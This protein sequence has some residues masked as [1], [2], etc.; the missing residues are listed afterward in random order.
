MLKFPKTYGPWI[1]P[2]LKMDWRFVGS[3]NYFLKREGFVFSGLCL[4]I[5]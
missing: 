3:T 5:A 2:F 4:K 1:P